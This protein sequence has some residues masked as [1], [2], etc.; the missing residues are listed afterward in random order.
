MRHMIFVVLL[1]SNICYL[2]AQKNSA[3]KPNSDSIAIVNLE[4]RINLLEKI[5]KTEHEDKEFEELLNDASNYASQEKEETTDLSKKFHSGTRQQQGLNPNISV[6]GDFFAAVSSSNNNLISEHNETSYGNNGIYMRGLEMA[7]EAPLD[8]FTR[9]KVILHLH[10]DEIEVEE[11]YMQI[12]NLPLNLSLKAGKFYVEYGLLNRYHTHALPQFDRP[13]VAVNYFGIEGLGG[14]GLAGNILLPRLLFANS[15]TFDFSLVNGRDDISFTVERNLNMLYVGHFKNYYD[16]SE[17]CYL[18][19]T[20]SGVMG[21]NDSTASYNSYINSFGI[22]FNRLPPGRSKYRSFD[23]KTEFYYG[24]YE[25]A[26]KVIKSKGFYS[27]VQNKLNARFWIAGRI[28]YSEFPYDN[29][30]HEWDYTLCLDYWQSEFVFFRIQYQYNQRDIHA[31]L[32]EPVV[33]PS[34]HSIV[35]QVSWAMGPHKHEAY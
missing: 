2:K 18:E 9:G 25:T 34:D 14:L 20:L 5:I 10:E 31:V 22:H 15:S 12:L 32:Y 16:L 29:K 1:V 33:F 35:L 21:K 7:F 6:L 13:R 17:N 26:E 28:G 27:S 11:A 3:P 24:Y 8:P 23:W 4:N 19:F 30:Q